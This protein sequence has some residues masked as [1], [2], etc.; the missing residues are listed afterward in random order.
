MFFFF[1]FS[2]YNPNSAKISNWRIGSRGKALFFLLY[3][4]LLLLIL[5]GGMAQSGSWMGS[6][7]NDSIYRKAYILYL[8]DNEDDNKL[9]FE[10]FE[11]AASGYK[12]QENW[13]RFSDCMIKQAIIQYRIK[14]FSKVKEILVTIEDFLARYIEPNDTL[15]SDFYYVRGSCFYQEHKYSEAIEFLNKARQIR[16][17]L[18]LA[19]E[20]LSYIYN[21]LGGS[22]YY[23]S[24][25]A[26]AL[27]SFKQSI[28]LKEIVFSPDDPKLGSSYINCGSIYN[29]LGRTEEASNLFLKGARLYEKREG[30]DHF[31][32]GAAY[33]N[34]G[35]IYQQKADF[36]KALDYYHSALRLYEEQGEIFLDNIAKIYNNIG[37]IHLALEEYEEALE[38][39]L[40]SLDAK[41][42]INS[43][44]L[45][46]TFNN[47]GETYRKM[48]DY[49]KASN[50]FLNAIEHTIEL[51]GEQNIDL[52]RYYLNYGVYTI[53][54]FQDYEKGE[55]LYRKALDLCLRS[56]GSKHPLT[57]KTYLNI[58]NFF[59]RLDEL[60]SAL[61][62]TQK[63]I[64][65]LI[66]DFQEEDYRQ[67][68][69]IDKVVFSVE[70]LN[71]IKEKALLTEKKFAASGELFDLQLSFSTLELA[72]ALIEEIRSGFQTEESR[73]ILAQNEYSTYHKIICHALQLFQLTGEPVYKEKA[74][75]YSEKSKSANLLAAIRNIEA[76]ELGG[77]PEELIEEELE[78]RNDLNL[79]KEKVHEERE[80]EKS[81]EESLK[82]WEG[83][84]FS[85]QKRIDSLIEVFEVNYPDYYSL[86]YNTMVTTHEDIAT[87]LKPDEAI[88]EYTVADS[89]LISFLHTRKQFVV[90]QV[91][92][93]SLFH[94]NARFIRRILTNRN[95][96][97]GV[98]MDYT[99]FIHASHGLYN[100]LISPFEDLIEGYNLIIIPDETLAYIPFEIL[101]SSLADSKEPDYKNLPYLIKNHPISYSNSTTLLINRITRKKLSDLQLLAFAPNYQ[102]EPEPDLNQT[103]RRQYHDN[104]YPIPGVSEEVAFIHDLVGGD[105]FMDD[106]ATESNFKK[107]SP[108]YDLLHLA[109][110]TVIDDV[111][112]MYSK[113]VF[114]GSSE[115]NEDGLL[116]TFE[117]YGL[118]LNASMVVLSSCNTGAG[119][120]QKGEGVMSL[121]RGFIY[122]G[123]PSIIMTLWE[124]EDNSG[125]AIMKQFYTYLKKGYPKDEALQKAKLHFLE[126]ANMETAHPYFWSGYVNIGDSSPVFKCTTKTVTALLVVLL[127]ILVPGVF[128]YLKK[129]R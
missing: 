10:A 45:S 43:T 127:V 86:K 38:W 65:S 74:F 24:N 100:K 73:M 44:E 62:Y 111:N 92:I 81:N 110:H 120:M 21:N 80:K 109:M 27:E 29:R 64:I 95:F 34:L 47:I 12:A 67:N 68:P 57:S 66:D 116:N 4:I 104:L 125:V 79:Y 19:D 7:D 94:L 122:A 37:L 54:V 117:I 123:C 1:H 128:V 71:S 113:L 82:L 63:S 114:A 51:K 70:L 98:I 5:S 89:M 129:L 107:N 40:S 69:A 48:G 103:S 13:V 41:I 55:N 23:L 59:Y 119:K 77:I 49:E 56:F 85:L 8:Q 72:N 30:A 60:D 14:N 118:T 9:A 39:F 102:V 78:L 17:N 108:E 124:V 52:A 96:S 105:F 58:G 20:I 33:N 25:Y 22:Y 99:Q 42:R 46:S 18:S 16:E 53:E 75:E 121:S 32:L 50:Y 31:N 11:Q 88:L 83:Y 101:M 35:L 26:M 87:F 84:I 97:D 91:L 93:D 76:K 15:Y 106:Q 36:Q 126:G 112:P 90:N 28:T 3:C 115:D 61:F 6:T 2:N